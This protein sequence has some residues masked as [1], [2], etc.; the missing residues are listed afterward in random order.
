MVGVVLGNLQG[1]EME[2][3][4]EGDKALHCGWFARGGGELLEDF[5]H[6]FDARGW[7]GVCLFWGCEGP[8]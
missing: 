8:T 5:C 7:G 1:R 6:C 3:G 2:V 4:E